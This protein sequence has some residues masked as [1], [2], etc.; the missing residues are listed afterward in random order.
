MTRISKRAREEAADLCAIMA[1]SRQSFQEDLGVI[2]MSVGD[3]AAVV[4][5]SN[6]AADL[7][8]LAF[9]AS[10]I[11]DTSD[12]NYRVEWWAEADAMLREGW[13]P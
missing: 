5:A 4:G 6:S 3:V 10:E 1:T 13:S 8:D 7:A 11:P 2:Q 12:T 9:L